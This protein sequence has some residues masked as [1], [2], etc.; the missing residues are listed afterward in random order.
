MRQTPTLGCHQAIVELSATRFEQCLAMADRG[1]ADRGEAEPVP[2]ADTLLLIVGRGSRDPQANSE[3][4]R[5]RAAV[6]SGRRS[7]G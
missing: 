5:F 1:E 2:A 4:A 3:L 6:G 7:A